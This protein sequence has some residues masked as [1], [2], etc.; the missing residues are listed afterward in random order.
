M[1]LEE[2]T[3]PRSFLLQSVSA[4]IQQVEEIFIMP[5]VQD[6]SCFCVS[7]NYP[8]WVFFEHENSTGLGWQF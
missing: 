1:P 7:C 4:L 2:V 5:N 3:E 8:C 6:L